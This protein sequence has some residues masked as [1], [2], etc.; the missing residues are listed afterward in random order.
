V[1]LH[2][3]EISLTSKEFE[4]LAFLAGSP[5]LVFSK[6]ELFRTIWGMDPLD[7]NST[8]TVHINRLRQKIEEDPSNPQYILTVWGSGYKFSI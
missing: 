4:L 2:N 8:V 3:K 5:N 6:N 7:D 1:L